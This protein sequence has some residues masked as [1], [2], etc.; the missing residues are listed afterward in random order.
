MKS[1]DPIPHTGILNQIFYLTNARL[2]LFGW[3]AHGYSI[4]L[5]QFI[6]LLLIAVVVVY[7]TER[8]TSRKI[9]GLAA[10]VIVT[11]I[12]A[13][14]IQS[15]T[16]QIP[17]FLFE[18]IRVMSSLIGALIIGVFYALIRAQFAKGK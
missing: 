10:G 11:L 2:Y 16:T 17:D 12:G 1:F 15:V 9:G 7:V 6:I 4:N 3:P 18:G 13:F 8:L 5:I 14:L